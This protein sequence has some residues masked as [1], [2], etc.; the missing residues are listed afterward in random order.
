M[1]V[2]RYRIDYRIAMCG[3]L[4]AHAYAQVDGQDLVFTPGAKLQWTPL[5]KATPPDDKI[6]C[7]VPLV[8]ENTAC[9]PC[10]VG[11]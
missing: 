8:A 2:A 10:S 5:G 6:V 9:K 4:T 11:Q 3:G 7:E 1:Y